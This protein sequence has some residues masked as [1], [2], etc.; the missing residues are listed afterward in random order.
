MKIVVEG[1]ALFYEVLVLYLLLLLIFQD[2]SMVDL[3]DFKYGGANITSM[4]LVNPN[5]KKVAKVVKEGASSGKYFKRVNKF[6]GNSIPVN[7]Y[8]ILYAL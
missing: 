4:R 7:I 8:L 3:E 5:D 1:A 2:L 6:D